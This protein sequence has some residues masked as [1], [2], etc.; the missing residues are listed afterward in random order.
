MCKE[1]SHKTEKDSVYLTYMESGILCRSKV[2]CLKQNE[3][4]ILFQALY[5]TPTQN[6]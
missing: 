1:V 4:R 6:P 5:F 3:M 2:Q